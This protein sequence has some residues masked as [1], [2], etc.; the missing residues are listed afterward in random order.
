[1]VADSRRTAGRRRWLQDHEIQADREIR[2]DRPIGESTCF[3]QP[4][5]AGPEMGEL[6]VIHRLLGQPE[7]ATATPA[8]LD[9]HEDPR[10]AGI[11]RH[12]VQLRSSRAHAAAE[13]PPAP[14]GQ[15]GGHIV[16]GSVARPLRERPR[17]GW[18]VGGH[19]APYPTWITADL[20]GQGSHRVQFRLRCGVDRFEV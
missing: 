19:A 20:P 4:P 16:F 15:P 2:Q 3:E 13:E 10:R 1:M 17:R 14:R 9:D 18:D 8:H 12:E 11:H 5:D 7:V 6:A